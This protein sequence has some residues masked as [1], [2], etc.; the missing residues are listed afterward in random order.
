MMSKL[1]TFLS[2]SITYTSNF[3]KKT[4]LT[5]LFLGKLDLRI[6]VYPKRY[7]GLNL[8]KGDDRHGSSITSFVSLRLMSD[9]CLSGQL[10]LNVTLIE[11]NKFRERI[12]YDLR[13]SS[14]I[15]LGTRT[16]RGLQEVYIKVVFF[17]KN[18]PCRE[19]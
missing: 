5:G 4:F 10:F 19:N 17:V 14:N 2:L 3:E 9:W 6:Y 7:A 15:I 11:L 16:F 1:P 8:F 13:F 18:L 12:P